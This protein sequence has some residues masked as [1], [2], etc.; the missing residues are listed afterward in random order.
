M[1][2]HLDGQ[3][4]APHRERLHDVAVNIHDAQTVSHWRCSYTLNEQGDRVQLRF[5]ERSRAPAEPHGDLVKPAGPESWPEVAKAGH[6]HLDDVQPD[7]RARLVH[8]DKLEIGGRQAGFAFIDVRAQIVTV[9]ARQLVEGDAPPI[10]IGKEILTL[11]E[12]IAV[13]RGTPPTRGL[14]ELVQFRESPLHR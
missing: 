5:P 13:P 12:A 10:G 11:R 2:A 14:E 6:D 7:I 9:K 4:L 3:V 8:D 1:I